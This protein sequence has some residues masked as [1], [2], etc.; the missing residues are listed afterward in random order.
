MIRHDQT[1]APS[2]LLSNTT[3]GFL[4]CN[5]P[6]PVPFSGGRFK[7]QRHLPQRRHRGIFYQMPSAADKALK[8]IANAVQSWSSA[9]SSFNKPKSKATAKP[10]AKPKATLCQGAGGGGA[11]GGGGPSAEAMRLRLEEL[12]LA[13]YLL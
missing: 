7:G 3:T 2:P 6:P 12:R 5:S 4:A 10:K 1:P 13:L 9:F 8:A 11:A